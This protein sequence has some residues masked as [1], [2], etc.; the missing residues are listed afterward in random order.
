VNELDSIFVAGSGK[1]VW[2]QAVHEN[3]IEYTAGLQ[4]LFD[5][6]YAIDDHVRLRIQQGAF[7]RSPL[8]HIYRAKPM[9]PV[10]KTCKQRTFVARPRG[11]AE[12]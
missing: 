12:D 4:L 9:I 10:E 6:S 1:L 11:S 7:Y 3:G 2:H 8:A 5:N